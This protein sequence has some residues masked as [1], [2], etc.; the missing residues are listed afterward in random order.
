[1]LGSPRL[2]RDWSTAEETVLAYKHCELGNKWTILAKFLPG[3]SDNDTKNIWHS[4]IRSKTSDKR[5]FLRA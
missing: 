1:V 4:T 2:I 5:S 3:R